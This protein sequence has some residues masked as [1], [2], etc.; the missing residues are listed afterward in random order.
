MEN[1]IIKQY[2]EERLARLR[3]DY[4]RNLELV[5]QSFDNE[6]IHDLR[7]SMR[8]IQALS[9]YIDEICSENVSLGLTEELK[10]RIKR[11]NK[12]RD[13]QVQI[14]FLIKNLNK[15]TETIDF[16]F[17]LKKREKKQVKK[18]KS[19]IQLP[20]FSLNGDLFFYHLK[21]QKLACL[22]SLDKKIIA[23]NALSSLNEV[24]RATDE[25]IKGDFRTYHK[26]RLKIKKF[27]YIIE[28]IEK[29]IDSPKDKLKEIQALQTIL[30]EIQD[31]SV[32]LTMIEQFCLKKN[33]ELTN[34]VNF[35]K[36]ITQK[37]TVK[38]QEFWKNI[39][40]IDFWDNF[41]ITFL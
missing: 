17:Y 1:S 8:R 14:D 22:T 26:V 41:L 9:S 33:I 6:A 2:I 31:F 40:V 21:I 25:I 16:L 20:D 28:T 18:L 27:R 11:F 7:V 39:N 3:Q 5:C 13:V 15:F 36:F 37:R 38:E 23:E 29:I 32:L 19:I 24:K 30:G 34:F 35:M 4:A 12:L 10:L